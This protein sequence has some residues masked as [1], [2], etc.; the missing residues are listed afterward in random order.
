MGT[1][2]WLQGAGAWEFRVVSSGVEGCFLRDAAT[3]GRQR[4]NGKQ[5]LFVESGRMKQELEREGTGQMVWLLVQKQLSFG[6]LSR[7]AGRDKPRPSVSRRQARPPAVAVSAGSSTVGVTLS[8]S[9]CNPLHTLRER[10][11]S[12]MDVPR[13]LADPTDVCGNLHTLYG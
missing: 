10:G 9:Y 11:E 4:E 5:C 13:P 3:A 7:M 8:W 12:E 2:G 6:R 1:T